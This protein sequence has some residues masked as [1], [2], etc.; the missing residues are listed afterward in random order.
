MPEGIFYLLL[1]GEIP[2]KEQVDAISKE[3]AARA[4]LPHVVMM[5][6]NFPEDV[7]PMTQFATAIAAL[8]KDS[9]F[10]KAYSEGISKMDYW[11]VRYFHDSRDTVLCYRLTRK[12]CRHADIILIKIY[13]LCFCNKYSL[14]FPIYL[15]FDSYKT[16]LVLYLQ[17]HLHSSK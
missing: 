7:H 13:Q 1:T 6:N 16:F 2:T 14:H 3:W 9:K 10:A 15:N 4:E 8:N 5:L 12:Q 17:H 11:M